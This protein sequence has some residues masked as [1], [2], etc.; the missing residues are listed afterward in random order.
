MK[1]PHCVD[2]A[3]E[4]PDLDDLLTKL[5]KKADS[6]GWFEISDC[7]ADVL[8]RHIESESAALAERHRCD[9]KA[10]QQVAMQIIDELREK[11]SEAH[12][13]LCIAH[14]WLREAIDNPGEPLDNIDWQQL[15]N[16]EESLRM[17]D[18]VKNFHF[19]S[20]RHTDPTPRKKPWK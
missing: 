9:H 8:R 15:I 14:S 17:S 19:S 11:L 4:A 3:R 16:N 1:K 18:T 10:E 12:S 6:G 7:S 13:W 20:G 2:C 5:R